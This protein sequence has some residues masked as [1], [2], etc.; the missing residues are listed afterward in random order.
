[1]WRSLAPTVVLAGIGL[2]AGGIYRYFADHAG[3]ATLVN[4]IR[5]CFHGMGLALRLGG[6]SLFYV[7]QQ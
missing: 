1:M 4:Y 5:S 6:S 2:L 7:A 3:E